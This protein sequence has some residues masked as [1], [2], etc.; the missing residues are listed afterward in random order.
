MKILSLRFENLN[1]LKGHWK[2]DFT[3]APFD[4]SALFA[5]TGP[6]G[7][8][9][10]TILDAICL[11]L[12][13]QT[14]RLVVTENQNQLMTRHTAS[15]LAEVEFEVKD[16]AYRAFWS[17]RRAK[18][19]ADGNLQTPKAELATLDGDIIASSLQAVRKQVAKI[20]GLDFSRF[21]K[22]MMLSQGQFSAFLEAK[23][24]DRA[25]LL[26]ELTGTEIYAQI[27]K[28]IF[29]SHR[30]AQHE[31]AT[32]QAKSEGM[33][34]LSAEQREQLNQQQAVFQQQQ[35]ELQQQVTQS[36]QQLEWY[37][38]HQQLHQ[39]LSEQQHNQ[40]QNDLEAKHY[41]SDLERLARYQPALAL[42]TDYVQWQK[43]QQEVKQCNGQIE[44]VAVQL[45]SEQ[46][47]LTK[48][49]QTLEKFVP[50]SEQELKQLHNQEQVIIEQVMPIDSN[51]AHHQQQHVQFEKQ[52]ADINQQVINEQNLLTNNKLKLSEQQ[53]QIENLQ[54]QLQQSQAFE[55]L[56]PSI[57]MMSQSFV[58]IQQAN[59]VIEKSNQALQD[60]ISKLTNNKQ[61]LEN[62]QQNLAALTSQVNSAE[63]SVSNSQQSLQAVLT[64]NQV[65]SE[66]E[67][68]EQLN[69]LQVQQ[70]HWLQAQKIA[71]DW[72]K[73]DV[74]LNK[75]K[76]EQHQLTQE[77]AQGNA[78]LKQ[79]REQYQQEN[80]THHQ[81]Q[82]IV[83]QQQLIQELSD[84]RDKLQQ[85]EPCPLCGSKEHPA[86]DEYKEQQQSSY[87]QQL[88]SQQQ[89]VEQLKLQGQSLAKDIEFK[90]Q[91]LDKLAQAIAEK[92]QQLGTL[93]EQWQQLKV[94]VE[95]LFAI[96]QYAE[97][98][99]YVESFLQQLT[100]KL[101]SQ[102]HIRNSAHQLNNALQ[103]KQQ[104]QTTAAQMQGNIAVQQQ[105][106][107]HF[108]KQEQQLNEQLSQLN[109]QTKVKWQNICQLVNNAGLPVPEFT[110]FEAWLAHIEKQLALFDS[111]NQQL[112]TA[113]QTVQEFAQ[114]QQVQEQ[115]IAHLTE[116]ANQLIAQQNNIKQ[117]L[118]QLQQ[119]RSQL[120]DE[121]DVAIARENIANKRESIAAQEKQLNELFS[122]GETGSFCCRD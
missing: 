86:I 98:K 15:C 82:V 113:Q 11:A 53:A 46:T 45:Q 58:D 116:Q 42:N 103:Q 3:A 20:T 56:K 19:K 114:Q 95:C 107:A 104:L 14:P 110:D 89:L 59:S 33:Q 55:L 115:G 69:A 2:I 17:Q 120:L 23:A 31:L 75:F 40:Q 74:E 25:E 90:Q 122:Q 12:Y 4:Q 64:E 38:Q 97:I 70:P 118:E 28:Q 30:E 79:L 51:I 83:E 87:Q 66:Q 57:A 22:S 84:Y 109:E 37:K 77:I 81:L 78:Q 35:P 1:S 71:E 54:S 13:H 111:L 18:G 85:D 24:K 41:Q 26:E 67:F 50:Q 91:T 61:T 29:D 6:T 16:Q 105:Q 9:K 27:S 101:A 93:N 32:L 39:Q 73:E 72:Q 92:S 52:K 99:A 88:V 63:Q 49:Q 94:N 68:N 21:T 65:H 10:T 100:N 34:L 121:P 44:Q 106:L 5:I 117:I 48:A 119:Q 102:E 112:T 62:E 60:T 108:A 8:G 47:Q 80:K 96:E 36:Q 43:H 76:A 7:A